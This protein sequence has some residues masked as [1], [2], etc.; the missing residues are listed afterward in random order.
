MKLDQVAAQLYTLRDH[1]KNPGDIARSLRKVSEIGYPAV[2][3]S[4]MAPIPEEDLVKICEDEGLIICATHEPADDILHEPM[5]VVERL[6]KLGCKH[7]AYP[8]PKDVD[9]GSRG[10]V[11]GLIRKL[12][13][14]GKVLADNDLVLSYHN[15]ALEFRKMEGRVILEMIYEETD[16]QHLMAEID[17]YWV[18]MGGADPVA[19]CESLEGRLPLVHLKDF[20]VNDENKS[21]FM[22]VGAGNLDFESIVEA[23]DDAGTEW[24]I[25]EQDTCPGDPFDSLAESFEYIRDN[26]VD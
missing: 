19:W 7:T 5:K 24:F 4:G 2:Q 21:T 9:F 15:H 25:V 26:L 20:G 1:L 18:Q 3:V 23:C 13:E 8:Y 22:E 12:N 11:Q 6:K 17:T 10:S 14:A 16:D